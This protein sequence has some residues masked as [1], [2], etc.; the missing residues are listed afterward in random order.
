MRRV[1]MEPFAQQVQALPSREIYYRSR[2]NPISLAAAAATAAAWRRRLRRGGGGGRLVPQPPG[3]PSPPLAAAAAAGQLGS[4][5]SATAPLPPTPIFG[6][7][8]MCKIEKII[9]IIVK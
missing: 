1:H 5:L 2:D 3:S 4:L 9:A 6:G 7:G 8:I